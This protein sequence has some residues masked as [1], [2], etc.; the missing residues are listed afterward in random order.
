M[1]TFS[2]KPVA[3]SSFAST[4]RRHP[5][6]MFGLPFLSLV[7]AASY[8]LEGLTKTRYDLH[9]QKVQTMEK[10]EELGMKENRKRVDIREEYYVS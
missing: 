10:E 5:F 3:A 6:L 8:G 7:V 9:G 1:P 2:S 4:L